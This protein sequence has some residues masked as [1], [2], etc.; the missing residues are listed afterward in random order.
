M[1]LYCE[2]PIKETP[3]SKL[4]AIAYACKHDELWKIRESRSE[5]R[6]RMMQRTDLK[7]KCGS[8]RFFCPI[9]AD[10]E[11]TCYG[12]CSKGRAVRPRTTKGCK[13]HERKI[14]NA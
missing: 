10:G 7:G 5:K 11:D 1:K 6:K 3:M 14:D 8:C 2:V 13:E 4:D 12:N 9:T